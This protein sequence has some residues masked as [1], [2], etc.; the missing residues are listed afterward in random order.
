MA[1]DV[2]EPVRE[3]D[4]IK[5]LC[6]ESENINAESDTGDS[7]KLF[8]KCCSKKCSVMV[9]INCY[10]VF[11]KSCSDRAVKKLQKL[12]DY[13]VICCEGVKPLINTDQISKLQMENNLLKKLL[14][15]M[16]DKNTIL[17]ENNGLLLDKIKYLQDKKT[18][19]KTDIKTVNISKPVSQ[20]I[21]E[22]QSR[23]SPVSLTVLS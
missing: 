8:F 11:H 5:I 9:C 21:P 12:D 2:V 10:S 4:K 15:E 20:K 17:K 22:G 1:A 3:S 7:S 18:T 6:N 14:L 19:T 13:K 16:E 23:Q